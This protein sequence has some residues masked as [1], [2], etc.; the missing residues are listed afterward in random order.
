MS[1]KIAELYGLEVRNILIRNKNRKPQADI[2]DRERR[3][4]NIEGSFVCPASIN[5]RRIVLVDD[6]CTTG[7]TLNECARALAANGAGK[8]SALVVARG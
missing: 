7:G 1:K 3:L 4:N 2:K 8:I 5:G 6:I